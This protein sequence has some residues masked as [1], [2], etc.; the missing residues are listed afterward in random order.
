MNARQLLVALPALL[1]LPMI[2]TCCRDESDKLATCAEK[3]F[4]RPALQQDSRISYE[5]GH[6]IS[7][8]KR[9]TIT[10]VSESVLQSQGRYISAARFEVSVDGKKRP[11]LTFGAIGIGKS[12]EDATKTAVVEWY[13]AAGRPLFAAIGGQ[14]PESFSGNLSIYPGSTGFRGEP[15]GGWVDGSPTMKQRVI[16]ALTDYLPA[17]GGTY[18]A[19]DVKITVE[20][21]GTIDG[22]CMIDGKES[23]TAMTQLK[24]LAWPSAKGSY[25]FKQAYV[26]VRRTKS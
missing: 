5:G 7:G 16:A 19:I 23:M 15:P 12:A 21:A 20:A 4:E 24:R 6:V 2:T 8:G 22:Q 1:F 13:Q 3:L 25:M 26:L 17:T 11:E 14:P 10:P 9:I 18:S